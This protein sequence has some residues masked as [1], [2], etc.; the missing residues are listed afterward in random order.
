MAS[1]VVVGRVDGF[2]ITEV[3][4][5]DGDVV[6]YLVRAPG[7]AV[8]G[9]FL[10]LTAAIALLFSEAKVTSDRAMAEKMK[11]IEAIHK[12]MLDAKARAAMESEDSSPTPNM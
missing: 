9:Q 10:D 1:T 7:G 2:T 5:N 12:A 8:L 4:G 3:R 11:I 6:G